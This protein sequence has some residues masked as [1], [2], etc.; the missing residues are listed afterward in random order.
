MDY[1][2]L[3]KRQSI[4]KKLLKLRRLVDNLGIVNLSVQ[5]DLDCIDRI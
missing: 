4:I 1:K 5:K 3:E 2:E